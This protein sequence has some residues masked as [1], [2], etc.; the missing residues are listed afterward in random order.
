MAAYQ[1]KDAAAYRQASA[2]FLQLI[3]DLDELLAT[4]DEFLLGTWLE[5][6]KRWGATDAERA[7]LEWNARRI[8]TLWGTGAALRDY[9]W[10]EW[11]GL[12]TGFYA[13]RWEIFFQRQQEALDAGKPFDQGA[14]HAEIYRF[15]E[16]LV[17]RSARPIRQSPKATASRWRAGS[18]TSTVRDPRSP[19]SRPASR[20]PVRS[21]CRAWRA[22]LA[23]DGIV[24]TESYWATDVTKDK[25]AWWQ[26]DLE[27]PTKVGRVVVVGYYGD[28]RYYGFTVE[29][30]L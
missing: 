13:K 26:V 24:D 21:R 20:S 15:E 5:D 28:Q 6:A 16:R 7:K 30:S 9:A 23:N 17:Q 12:L 18:S 4:S 10:K 2:E 8:L 29:G 11:S 27:K 25:A 14:C 22:N 1:A 19:T 3:R